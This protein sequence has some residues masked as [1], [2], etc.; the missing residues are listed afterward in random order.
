MRCKDIW[1][2]ELPR[3]P[4]RLML[5]F[6]PEGVNVNHV[7]FGNLFSGNTG[8]IKTPPRRIPTGTNETHADTRGF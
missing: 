7:R 4:S 6:L 5:H 8:Q 2:T 1:P 3:R